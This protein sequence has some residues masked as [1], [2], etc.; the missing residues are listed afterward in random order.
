MN[1]LELPNKP[2]HRKQQQITSLI[3]RQNNI[4][5]RIK[6]RKEKENGKGKPTRCNP[7]NHTEDY[8]RD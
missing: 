2:R 8:I 5:K 6:Q 4:Q 1:S 3:H 7:L